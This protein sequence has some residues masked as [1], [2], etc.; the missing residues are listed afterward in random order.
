VCVCV[1]DHEIFIDYS[2]TNK[3][4]DLN[5][6]AKHL[7]RQP[8]ISQLNLDIYELDIM[9]GRETYGNNVK[10]LILKRDIV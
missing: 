1:N 9:R 4:C 10:R 8:E 6:S 7:K 3:F 2:G 5:K